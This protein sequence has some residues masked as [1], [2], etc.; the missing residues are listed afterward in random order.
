MSEGGARVSE[1]DTLGPEVSTLGPEVDTRGSEVKTLVA[2]VDIRGSE[3]STQGSEVMACGK[4]ILDR[5]AM[6][7]S[8]V[9]WNKFAAMLACTPVLGP[10]S[11]KY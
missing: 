11:D 4:V 7:V 2:E 10:V 3:V 5:P 8:E 9:P 6:P 1:V